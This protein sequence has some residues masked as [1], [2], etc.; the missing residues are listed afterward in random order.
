[1]R[2]GGKGRISS[3]NSRIRIYEWYTR[4]FLVVIRNRGKNLETVFL[5]M[6]NKISFYIRLRNFEEIN[7]CHYGEMTS[8]SVSCIN[9]RN[10]KKILQYA[11]LVTSTEILY[12][13]LENDIHLSHSTY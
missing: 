7:S 1:M 10:L 6:R 11:L 13:F 9:F 5:A 2:E 12:S 8:R 4:P 3:G